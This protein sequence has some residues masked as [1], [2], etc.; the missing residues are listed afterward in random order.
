MSQLVIESNMPTSCLDCPCRGFDGFGHNAYCTL[1][2]MV[3]GST[4]GR[5]Q[6]CPI[7]AELPPHGR[8]I[9]A[10]ALISSTKDVYGEKE[11]TG[12]RGTL[13]VP[14]GGVFKEYIDEAPTILESS[15]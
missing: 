10:D 2:P 7:I 15:R 4:E 6:T 3:E 12:Q 8:L 5:P 1:S 13:H 9:D 11:L 14:L